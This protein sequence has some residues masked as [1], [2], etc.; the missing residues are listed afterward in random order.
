MPHSAKNINFNGND[1]GNKAG[2]GNTKIIFLSFFLSK[3]KRGGEILCSLFRSLGRKVT[4]KSDIVSGN[5]IK[6]TGHDLRDHF[7]SDI[8]LIDPSLI[9]CRAQKCKQKIDS[10]L[11]KQEFEKLKQNIVQSQYIRPITVEKTASDVFVLV[12]G[13]YR[14]LAAQ[15]LGLSMIPARVQ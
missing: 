14:L 7:E 9:L 10:P 6:L 5:A 15:E 11:R 1:F 3:Y 2:I 13:Y 12:D 8:D 4:T